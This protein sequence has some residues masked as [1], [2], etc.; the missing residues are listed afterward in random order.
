MRFFKAPT[1]RYYK[2]MKENTRRN[3]TVNKK[4]YNQSF[5]PFQLHHQRFHILLRQAFWW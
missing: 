4:E 1:Y 5:Q 2:M 3:G